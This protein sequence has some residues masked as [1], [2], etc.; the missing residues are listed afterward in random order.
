M[1]L[2]EFYENIGYLENIKELIKIKGFF[3]KE[4]KNYLKEKLLTL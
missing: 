2:F 4:A 3:P 1:N